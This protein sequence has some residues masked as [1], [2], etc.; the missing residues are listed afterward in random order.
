MATG[1]FIGCVLIA[2]ES[3]FFGFFNSSSR[4]AP[5]AIFGYKRSP[6]TGIS[7]FCSYMVLSNMAHMI[8]IRLLTIRAETISTRTWIR[9]TLV[10]KPAAF[11]VRRAAIRSLFHTVS[12]DSTSSLLRCATWTDTRI[13]ETGNETILQC[14]LDQ[15]KRNQILPGNLSFAATKYCTISINSALTWLFCHF[16]KFQKIGKI[17]N[18]LNPG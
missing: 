6:D 16:E 14:E 3:E 11:Y 5:H 12:T 1:I 4:F 7:I 10:G 17:W 2:P 8:F 15:V 9:A 13:E 18:K